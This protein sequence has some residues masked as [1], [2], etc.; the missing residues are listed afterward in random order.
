[1]QLELRWRQPI[2]EYH[3]L[4]HETKLIGIIFFWHVCIMIRQG[5]FIERTRQSQLTLE[6][7]EDAENNRKY[8]NVIQSGLGM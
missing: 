5:H 1:M 6:I 4:N 3:F 2:Y 8:C 7:P